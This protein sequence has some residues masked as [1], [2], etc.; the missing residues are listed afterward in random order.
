MQQ[1]HRN[2]DLVVRALF[3]ALVCRHW[4]QSM[5]SGDIYICN[6]ALGII[7]YCIEYLVLIL[8]YHSWSLVLHG[9]DYHQFSSSNSSIESLIAQDCL[10]SVK[11]PF[12]HILHACWI[13]DCLHDQHKLYNVSANVPQA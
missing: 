3:V 6:D 4:R 12:K 11:H 5:H 10:A 9:P 7:G 2:K 8:A 1:P 13:S